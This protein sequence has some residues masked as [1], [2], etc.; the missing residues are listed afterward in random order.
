MREVA[1]NE[2]F[3][4]ARERFIPLNATFELTYRCNLSCVHCY[5]EENTDGELAT[6][7][8]FSVIEQLA[9]CGTLNMT[10]TG[11][12]ALMREDFFEIAR[13][14][15]KRNMGISLI[16][17]G[18]LI[19]EGIVEKMKH[20]HFSNISISLHGVTPEI[21][22]AVTGTAG[23][24]SRTVKAVKL[25]A[26]SGFKVTVK[27]SVM[28][29]NAGEIERINDFCNGIGAELS[30]N[31]SLCPTTRGS[32]RPLNYRLS[33]KELRI[34]MM[35]ETG[36]KEVRGLTR[37]CNAGL[38]NVGI[39]PKGDIFPCNIIRLEA[40]NLRQQSFEDIWNSS[41]SLQWIRGLKMEDFEECSK[42]K[43]LDVCVRCP[44]QALSE[45]GD[46]LVPLK[47]S[48]RI[49][50]IRKEAK[51]GKGNPKS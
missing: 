42:C 2:I 22:E 21:H 18:T 48:C 1:T 16:S 6:E 32:T 5:Q 46:L 14:A 12:E 40:G 43:L 30:A 4:K 45:E 3:T 49:A 47:E 20:L 38:C 24:F 23:S 15:R 50:R 25:L 27:T 28:K 26:E 41:P 51:N 9:Q 29:Q 7:E 36:N 11:G 34:Y 39:S 35:W 13:H 44:G 8:V 10:L 19:E 33:D 37:T 17:N 31:P